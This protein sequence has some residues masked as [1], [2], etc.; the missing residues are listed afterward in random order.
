LAKPLPPARTAAWA[1][2]S[3]VV[4]AVSLVSALGAALGAVL[5]LRARQGIATATQR[6]T[7]DVL[8]TNG[9]AAEP[10]RAGLSAAACREASTE[11]NPCV[12]RNPRAV[13]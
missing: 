8:H 6:A 2:T 9:L 7:H 12:A 13:N 11:R 1:R 4:C 10:L 5:R 3:A